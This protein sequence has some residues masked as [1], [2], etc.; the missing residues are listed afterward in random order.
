MR[1]RGT[2]EPYLSKPLRQPFKFDN[3]KVVASSTR[4]TNLGAPRRDAS[5]HLALH[6]S[7]RDWSCSFQNRPISMPSNAFPIAQLTFFAEDKLYPWETLRLFRRIRRSSHFSPQTNHTHRKCYVFFAE[8][9][10]IIIFRRKQIPLNIF[11]W[12]KKSWKVGWFLIR[13][14]YKKKA[15]NFVFT[16]AENILD[17]EKYFVALRK[18]FFWMEF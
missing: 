9:T 2:W 11:G 10:E 1:W 13:T 14:H 7:R 17:R 5:D 16:T 3:P 4:S 12:Q 6:D 8:S 18:K 15:A